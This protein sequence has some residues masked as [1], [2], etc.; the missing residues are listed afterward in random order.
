M[1][2]ANGKKSR[3]VVLTTSDPQPQVGMFYSKSRFAGFDVKGGTKTK[4][5]PLIVSD[6]ASKVDV[7]L[8]LVPDKSG[9]A[10]ELTATPQ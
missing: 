10:I 8:A 1:V 7:R 4:N 2:D 5:D 9:T 3:R 6:P